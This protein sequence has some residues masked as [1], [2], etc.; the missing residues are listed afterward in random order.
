MALEATWVCMAESIQS[1]LLDFVDS[2]QALN[3]IRNL[4][5]NRFD[6]ITGLFT[7]LMKEFVKVLQ[8]LVKGFQM[9]YDRRFFRKVDPKPF[10]KLSWSSSQLP[11]IVY[12]THRTL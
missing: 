7:R 12:T 2:L 4:R 1:D 5:N 11:E 10:R 3:A 8:R 9:I 6:Q